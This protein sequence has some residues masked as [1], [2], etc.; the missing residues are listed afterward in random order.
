MD[1]DLHCTVQYC[2]KNTLLR[3]MQHGDIWCEHQTV[4]QLKFKHSYSFLNV[5]I[6]AALTYHHHP[7]KKWTSPLAIQWASLFSTLSHSLHSFSRYKAFFSSLKT[8]CW[9]SLAECDPWQRYQIVFVLWHSDCI[10]LPWCYLTLQL[11]LNN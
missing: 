3:A 7:H 9:P 6:R 2:H 8:K 11:W 10:Y 5:D 4:Y 1:L